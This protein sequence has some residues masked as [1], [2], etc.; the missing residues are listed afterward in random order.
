VLRKTAPGLRQIALSGAAAGAGVK[1]L[2]LEKSAVEIILVEFIRVSL[3]VIV[4]ERSPV[5][6]GVMGPVGEA[7]RRFAV[8][9][10]L[11]MGRSGEPERAR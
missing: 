5:G 9:L 3:I 7:V 10:I 8:I 1:I 4:V 11:G 6:T 2:V